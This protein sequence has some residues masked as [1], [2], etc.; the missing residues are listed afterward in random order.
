METKNGYCF[1][2]FNFK[3]EEKELLKKLQ[4][5]LGMTAKEVL[6]RAMKAYDKK[7]ENYEL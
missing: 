2:G 4:K 1:T 7:T 5:R 6:V 3:P